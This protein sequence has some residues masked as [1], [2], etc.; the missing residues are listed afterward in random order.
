MDQ[1]SELIW[2]LKIMAAPLAEWPDLRLRSNGW[3]NMSV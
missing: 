2:K 1:A 3:K